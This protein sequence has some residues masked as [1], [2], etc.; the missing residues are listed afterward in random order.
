MTV[1]F[2]R[3]LIVYL[4]L[5]VSNQIFIFGSEANCHLINATNRSNKSA[6]SI[7]NKPRFLWIDAAANFVDFANSKDNIL[8]DLTLA[9]NSGF[10]HVVVDVRLTSGNVLFST[11]KVEP[12]TWVGAWRNGVYTKITRTATWDYL[13]AFI[14][15]G[16]EL[17]LQVYAGFNT[18]VGGQRTSLGNQGL[19]YT[20]VSKKNWATEI[21]T[22]NGIVNVLDQNET[23][24]K[25]FNPVN[26]QVQEYLLGI[27]E[28]LAK[29]YPDLDG[30]ILDRGRFAGLQSDFS[31][32][33]RNKFEQYIG[34]IVQNYPDDIMTPDMKEGTLPQTLP[35]H[36]KKWLEFRAKN[37][38]DFMSNARN[39]IKSNNSNVNFGVYVGG[40]Y[41]SYY[42]TGVNWA[43]KTYDTANDYPK[44]ATDNYK[45]FGYADLMDVILIGA[46]ASPDRVFGTTEWTIQGFCSRAKDKIKNDAIVVGGPDVGNGNWA[47]STNI[48]LYNDA[49]IASVGAVNEV[50]DGYFLFDMIHL[51]NRNQWQYVHTGMYG[52]TVENNVIV[53][54]DDATGDIII[55]ERIDSI[56][57]AVF[58][59]NADIGSV[60]AQQVKGIGNGAFQGCVNLQHIE[61]PSLKII[62]DSAFR[63]VKKLSTLNLQQVVKIGGNAFRGD[64]LLSSVILPNVR[65]LEINAFRSCSALISID[66]PQLKTIG[67]AA[68]WGTSIN[69]VELESAEFLDKYAFYSIKTLES[70]R[71][72]N[73]KVI[74]EGAFHNSL[75][76]RNVDLSAAKDL[77]EVSPNNTQQG[78]YTFPNE[79]MLTVYVSSQDKIAL[80]PVNRK[81]DVTVKVSTN[82]MMYEELGYRVFPNPSSEW[83]TVTVPQNIPI[84]EIN[85][86]DVSGR[87]VLNQVV[88]GSSERLN[89]S[90]LTN[91]VYFVQAGHMN[92]KLLIR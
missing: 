12:V 73:V 58:Q 81:Y 62:G 36:F 42:G 8:R 46:Y 79:T 86:R 32:Y 90:G 87:T 68:F 61:M 17:G 24:S 3:F 82:R 2:I 5:Y 28:D 14:E 77:Y 48:P 80:F 69:H 23:G 11:N 78:F 9:K 57:S 65:E 74:K 1:P 39:R 64:S 88:S 22:D 71:L 66:M 63:N 52:Y 47:S 38:H 44:W 33:T 25:F 21:I 16:H 41:S 6:S 34:Q 75:F 56:G 43:S 83:I 45:S 70:I 85:V 49:I 40:W 19:L 67:Q 37:I 60:Y 10:T 54:W 29:N 4:L 72:P 13:L 15:I 84:S 76:L 55:P 18:F 7:L 30:I 53:K 89:V 27:L 92:V 20:D 91:G 31:S 35:V 51:K 50:C 26:E 59:Y